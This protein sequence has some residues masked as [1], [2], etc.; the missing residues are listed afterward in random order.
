MKRNSKKALAL[1]L[2][3]SLSAACFAGCTD[4][5]TTVNTEGMDLS[6]Y[7]IQGSPS[8][9]YYMEA[10]A[11]VLSQYENFGETEFAKELE[12][13]TGVKVTYVHPAAG[14]GSQALSLMIAS[15]EMTD[16]VESNWYSNNDGPDRSIS[17]GTIIS[18]NKLMDDGY[19]PNLKKLLDENKEIDKAVKT[20]TGEYYVFPFLK[21]GKLLYKS[22]GLG[23]RRDWLEELGLEIPTTVEEMENVLRQFKEKKGIK[24]PL[25]CKS[26]DIK[27][28]FEA[29]GSTTGYYQKDG[30]MHFGPIQENYKNALT[31]LNRWYEEGLL[32]GNFMAND[33]QTLNSAVLNDKVGV[34]FFS[35]GGGLGTWLDS[36]KGE[37]FDMVGIPNLLDKEGNPGPTAY[38]GAYPGQSSAAISGSCEVPELAAKFLDYAYGEE[39]TLLYNFGIEGVSYEMKNGVPTY[40]DLIVNNP[41]GLT[42]S[43]AMSKYFRASGS[44]PFVQQENYIKGYYHRPNQM[45]SLTNWLK[46]YEQSEDKSLTITFTPEESREQANIMTEV[47][48]YVSKMRAEFIMGTTDISE[49]DNYVEKIKKLNFDRVMEIQN[50]AVKRYNER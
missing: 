44:G 38:S 12:K 11:A 3:I 40:T 42:M 33:T 50:A 21:E 18:L 5:K 9:T 19:A 43:E 41:D 8:L 13:R 45:E 24:T 23:V 25:S 36:K 46:Y 37:K 29:L 27:T 10:P 32:D 35:G 20:D 22:G 34:T 7:P 1:V 2:G 17:E 26:S 16:I 30:E 31:V 39:G 47:D 48:K 15:D 28:L 4:K 6:S 14:Q 49:F